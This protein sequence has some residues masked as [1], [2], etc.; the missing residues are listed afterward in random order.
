MVWERPDYNRVLHI[1][2]DDW[3]EDQWEGC[4]AWILKERNQV[5][6]T[7]RKYT[8]DPVKVSAAGAVQK[9]PIK[10]TDLLGIAGILQR[11]GSEGSPAARVQFNGDNHVVLRVTIF[12]RGRG[13]AG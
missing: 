2:G 12:P 13:C 6:T 4:A 7:V 9:N 8:I 3:R 5:R 11:V 1:F 10:R